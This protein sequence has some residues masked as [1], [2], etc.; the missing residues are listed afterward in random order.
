MK[1]CKTN[2]EEIRTYI[3]KWDNK[4]NDIKKKIYIDENSMNAL[5]S[6]E[7]SSIKFGKINTGLLNYIVDSKKQN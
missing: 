5:K 3:N 2:V 7:I 1:Q 4:L 6:N